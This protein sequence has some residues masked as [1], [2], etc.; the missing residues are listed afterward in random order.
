MATDKSEPKIGNIVKIAVVSIVTLLAIRL[1]LV[2]Y[3][4]HM[5]D[6]ERRMKYVEM[7]MPKDLKDLRAD[8]AKRLSGVD[9]SMQMLATKGR[10]EPGI[11]P[12]QPKAEN[13]KDTLMGWMQM[14]RVSDDAA[15][16]PAPAT[17]SHDA[18]D[19]G[20]AATGDAATPNATGDAGAPAQID[21]G[22]TITTPSGTPS[23]AIPNPHPPAP[24]GSHS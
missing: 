23:G 1:G 14:P 24:Q 10:M 13:A 16:P 5:F 2:T 20:A 22:G 4:N 7:G 15:A 6:N 8:E 9:Q 19:A 17:T 18:T 3:F 12:Q 21:A 11:E